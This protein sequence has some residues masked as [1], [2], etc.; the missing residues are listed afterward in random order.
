VTVGQIGKRKYC[1]KRVVEYHA[2]KCTRAL[3]CQK[4]N[5]P[6]ARILNNAM[7]K[8]GILN[9]AIN[10]LLS[11]VRHTN[12]LVIADRGFPFWPMIETVDIALVDDV[13]TVLAVLR[14][15]RP[16]FQIGKA[17][18]AGEFLKNNPES[19]RAA[20]RTALSGIDLAHEPHITFKKRV[21]NAIGLIRTG[22]TTQ[23]ANIILESA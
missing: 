11:R 17:W 5:P 22:D 2:F 12:T 23:Y 18:M 21:P 10:H 19:V 14:A 1:Q 6:S 13:P 20:F 16:N 9:P 8:T 7:I 4:A 15:I 3:V